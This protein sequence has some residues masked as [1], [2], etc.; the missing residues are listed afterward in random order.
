MQITG[1]NST[2]TISPQ[3]GN[4]LDPSILDKD[5]FL[6]LLVAQLQ[7]QDPLSP[8]SNEEYLSQMTQFSMLEQMQ[9]MN[10]SLNSSLALQQSSLNS[11][12]LDLLGRQVTAVVDT[13]HQTAPGQEHDFSVRVDTLA[14]LE[15]RI[16]DSSGNVIYSRKMDNR[17]GDIEIEWNGQDNNGHDVAAGD[18]TVEV[19]R[20]NEDGGAAG[21]FSVMMT[22]LVSG[23]DFSH[24]YPVL[25]VNGQD[26]SIGAVLRIEV[27]D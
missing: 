19:V 20:L 18:Y 22:G 25:S 2:N 8:L 9:N 17:R 6:R 3:T 5:D 7:H 1:V 24:G 16:K 13:I 12:A 14:D 27:E 10:T 26:V 4:S 11:Q 15:V 23:V 21:S